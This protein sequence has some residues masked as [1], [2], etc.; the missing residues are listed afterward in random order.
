[1]FQLEAEQ[2]IEQ[3]IYW[4]QVDPSGLGRP[5]LPGEVPINSLSV[6]MM[7]M[8]LVQQ[9]TEG[10]GQEVAQKYKEL[11]N[12]C[13]E[14]ILQHIQV[15]TQTTLCCFFCHSCIFYQVPSIHK[16]SYF[17]FL[18]SASFNAES[19]HSYLRERVSGWI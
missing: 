11:G 4:V 5:Q 1:M 13:V 9:L 18:S 6:P 12:W 10:R 2:M 7:L 19:W 14:Q 3:L 17:S 8:C 15:W 16:Y